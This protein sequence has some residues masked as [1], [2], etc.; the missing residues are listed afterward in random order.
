LSAKPKYS[1]PIVRKIDLDQLATISEQELENGEEEGLGNNR[2]YR[3][4]RDITWEQLSD[5]LKQEK[6]LFRRFAHTDDLD[7]EAERY[8]EER[9][10]ADQPE[11]DLWGLDIGVIGATLALSALGAVPFNSCNAGGFGGRHSAL[12]P[13]VAFYL[14]RTLAPEVLAMAEQADVGLDIVSGGIAR[15]Y[16]RSDFDLHRFAEVVMRRNEKRK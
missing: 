13:Y 10:E 2:A 6:A 4:L 12:F 1:L 11:E 9:E 8:E 3:D 16:G 7:R 15:L 5:A 14:P